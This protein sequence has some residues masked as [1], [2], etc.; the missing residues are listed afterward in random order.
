MLH[1]LVKNQSKLIN[2]RTRYLISWTRYLNKITIS[3]IIL[4]F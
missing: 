2:R 1:E 3:V 4:P